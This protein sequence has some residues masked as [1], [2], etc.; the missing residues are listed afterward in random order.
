MN[1]YQCST[2]TTYGSPF[3]YQYNPYQSGST[4][5]N[6]LSIAAATMG[7]D[8][9]GTYIRTDISNTGNSSYY[10]PTSSPYCNCSWR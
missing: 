8:T 5:A 4:I 7:S 10:R 9:T 3:P 6:Q 2:P 1:T